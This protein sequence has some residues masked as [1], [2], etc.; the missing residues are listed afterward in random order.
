[1]LKGLP[2]RMLHATTSVYLHKDE[3]LPGELLNG[4]YSVLKRT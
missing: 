3:M 2:P 4:V 1:M